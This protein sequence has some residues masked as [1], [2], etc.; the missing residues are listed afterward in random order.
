MLFITEDEFWTPW[1]TAGDKHDQPLLTHDRPVLVDVPP[2]LD[3]AVASAPPVATF[4]AQPLTEYILLRDAGDAENRI[5]IWYV[6]DGYTLEQRGELLA[7]VEAQFDALISDDA[8][9]EPFG[10]YKDFFNVHVLFRSSNE[11]GADDPSADLY[12]DTAFDASYLWDGV[13]QRLLYFD[14]WKAEQAVNSVRPDGVDIDMRFGI[15]NSEQYGGGGGLYATFAGKNSNSA[16]LARH[17]VGHSFAGLADEYFTPDTTY[18]GG[19]PSEINVT[20]DATG[21]KWSHWLGFDDGELGPIGVYEGARYNEVGVYRPTNNSKMRAL[22]RPFD[23]IAKEAFILGFYEEVDPIDAV[24]PLLAAVDGALINPDA[25]MWV[26]VISRDVID[27]E[28]QVNGDVV[29]TGDSFDAASLPAGR[30]TLTLWAGDQTD[31]V[32]LDRSSMEQTMSWSVQLAA[33]DF[34]TTDLSDA[35]FGTA[36]DD[37]ADGLAGADTLIGNGG[38]DAL[39]GGDGN[40]LLVGDSMPAD[41][42]WA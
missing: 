8:L 5:D 31:K 37:I 24:S 35:L 3:V 18:S 23:A 27:V 12:V 32:R 42:I 30:G 13:T 9:A 36:L 38:A 16:E 21:A 28:W 39:S 40:D 15:I 14:W 6:G 4:S 10:D 29:A 26:D 7:D 33:E 34:A 2:V 19:E 41:D 20:T 1:V 25:D 11:S 22:D 17:E